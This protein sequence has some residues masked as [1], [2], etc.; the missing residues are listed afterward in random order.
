[1]RNSAELDVTVPGA[2]APVIVKPVGAVISTE[3]S[4][5]VDVSLVIVNANAVLVPAVGLACD[6]ATAKHLPEEMQGLDAVAGELSMT[7]PSVL[8]TSTPTTARAVGKILGMGD[9]P[10]T[11]AESMSAPTGPHA[12]LTRSLAMHERLLPFFGRAACHTTLG[13]DS[14]GR[15]DKFPIGDA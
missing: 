10:F 12:S 11:S 13:G 3:P 8:A 7:A 6:T 9:P 1:L 14:D 15:K 2:E 5:W 4:C